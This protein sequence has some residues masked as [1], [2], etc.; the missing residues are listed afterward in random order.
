VNPIEV[1]E[2]PPS[3]ILFAFLEVPFLGVEQ[4]TDFVAMVPQRI[5]VKHVFGVRFKEVGQ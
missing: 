3:S 4:F 5:F 2:E 1:A